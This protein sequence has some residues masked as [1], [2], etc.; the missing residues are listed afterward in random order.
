VRALVLQ[1]YGSPESA[2]GVAE[3]Q[4]PRAWPGHVVV[5]VRAAGLNFADLVERVGLYPGAPKM[6]Y[7]TGHEF[8]GTVVS[9]HSSE[10]E[11]EVGQNVFGCVESGAF[12]ECVAAPSESVFSLPDGMTFEQAAS[13]P[14]AYTTAHAAVTLMGAAR[15]GEV[16]L[17]YA[18][19]G[20]LGIAAV[21]LLRAQG[22]SVIGVASPQK[23]RFLRG[24]GL[25]DPLCYGSRRAMLAA[26]RARVGHR[27]GVDLVVDSVGDF[28]TSY[29]M[30]RPGG[31]LVCVGLS[32]LLSAF[33]RNLPKVI[34]GAVMLPRV[35]AIRLMNDNR[36]VAGL[37]MLNWWRQRGNL[38]ELV[39][40]LRELT[41]AGKIRPV[42]SRTFAL[43]DAAAAHRCMHWRENMG[44]LVL[45]P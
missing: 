37:N 14:I 22:V 4:E 20:S 44:K 24:Q 33:N 17:V 41:E 43:E 27:G 40:P 30:L 19:A 6:P 7:V 28:R 11:F 16:A 10:S 3:V 42:V 2:L 45:L 1:R 8:A 15:P 39:A 31:R 35:N 36:A 9:V 5:K 32:R 13:F 38:E 18:A 29:Q 12:A 25:A 26:I 23:H 21:Q 34:A